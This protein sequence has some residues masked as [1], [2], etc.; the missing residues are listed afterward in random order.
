MSTDTI[1]VNRIRNKF[2]LR[3]F[4]HL[5]VQNLLNQRE[6]YFLKHYSLF[7]RLVVVFSLFKTSHISLFER[8][9]C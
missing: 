9:G 5:D 3:L 7:L 4:L 8:L 1:D 6:L 2:N